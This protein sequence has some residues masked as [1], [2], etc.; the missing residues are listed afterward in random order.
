MA[1]GRSSSRSSSPKKSA[2]AP[3]KVDP[4]PTQPATQQTLPPQQ[5]QQ[6]SGFIGNMASSM[7]GSMAGNYIA[8][9]FLNGNSSEEGEEQTQTN[10]EE[11]IP[12]V[13]KNS[14]QTFMD[15]TKMRGDDISQCQFYF[16]NFN[17]C[18]LKNFNK[19]F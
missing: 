2:P 1:K 8:N 6:G 16:D 10:Q 5:Q 14:Y 17:Q 4:K 3:K 12:E 11:F 15:C 18:K 7:V 9:K 19:D 13:C